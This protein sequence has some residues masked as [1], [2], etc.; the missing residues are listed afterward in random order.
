MALMPRLLAL[1]TSIALAAPCVAASATAAST[2]T[3]FPLHGTKMASM[4]HGIARAVQAAPGDYKVAITL[5]AMPVPSTLKTTPIRHAYVAW[6]INPALMRPPAKAGGKAAKS[7]S[8]LAGALAIPLH[9]TG[10]GTYAGTGIVMMKQVPAIIV[11]AEVSATAHTPALPL[12][13]VLVGRPGT[14]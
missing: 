2:T 1:T 11:T 8:P 7:A 14:T 4:A 10:T 9:M 5:S 13:G 6:A 3:T 12:W